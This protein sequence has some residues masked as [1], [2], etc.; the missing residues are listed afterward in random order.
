MV[1]LR[2][3][4]VLVLPC[5]AASPASALTV[6]IG[7]QHPGAFSDP[8]LV[9][10]KLRSARLV[11]PWD[12]AV[13]EP[14]AVRAWLA[15]VAADGMTPH[16]AFEHLSTDRC[17]A[18]PCA[19]PSRAAYGA[20]VRAFI[21]AFPQVRTYTA[22]NEA[23]HVPQ[24]T[25]PAP[26]AAA[27]YYDELRSA[28]AA[29]TIVAGDVLDSGSFVAWLRRFR[30]AAG[31]DARLWGLHNDSDVTYGTTSGTVAVLAAVPGTLWLE[32]TGGIVVRRVTGGGVALASD[33]GRAAAA[34]SRAF[35]IARARPRI[36]R[37]YVYQRRAG[38]SDLFDS[39]LVRPDGSAR[40]SLAALSRGLGDVTW[41]ASWSSRGRLV[42]RGACVAACA[43]RV[44]LALRS[45]RAVRRFSAPPGGTA[46]LRVRVSATLRSTL[47]RAY[48]RRIVVSAGTTPDR[49]PSWP[50]LTQPG[51]TT[52]V[53]APPA[54]RRR[55]RRP[56]AVQRERRVSLRRRH[57]RR[58]VSVVV[59]VDL[60]V[61]IDRHHRHHAPPLRANAPH[62]GLSETSTPAVRG[63]AAIRTLSAEGGA[64]QTSSRIEFRRSPPPEAPPE[65]GDLR[66]RTVRPQ[67]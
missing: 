57:V 16:V 51:G 29:C 10:L 15:A 19:L 28:C 46:L 52:H 62:P 24:P 54:R 22:W 5:V 58:H 4:L 48:S 17:P 18:R 32:E 12:A 34:I 41:R 20:A 44:R 43:G 9:A 2:A 66:L 31:S 64:L 33:E 53:Q 36:V 14:S 38:A 47:R 65:G 67:T 23:N 56:R 42:L 59:L 45:F 7:D 26:E 25:A 61:V 6:G 11:V 21:A 55:H 35:A 49:A 1:A 60:V 27:G 39:G 13:S 3:G 30:S 37:M 8:R 40:P 63:C 50:S